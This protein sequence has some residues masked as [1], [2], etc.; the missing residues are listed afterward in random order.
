M[1]TQLTP[2]MKQYLDIKK[3]HPD[4]IL[5]FRLGDFYEMFLEDAIAASKILDIALTSRQNDVPMCGVPYH[6]AESYIARLLKAGRRIAICEQME[7]VPSSGTVVRREVVRVITP[8]TVV[9]ANL[10]GGDDHNFLGSIVIA[11]ESIGMAFI[12]VS[13]GDFLV[14]SIPRSLDAFRGQIARF[15][16]KEIVLRESADPEDDAFADH[17]R[18]LGIATC[19]INDW[20]YDAG[21]LDGVIREVLGLANIKGLGIDTPV[22]I[23]AAGSI[24]HYLKD[25]HRRA[26][27][28]LKLPQR[29]T[30]A[31]RMVLDDA[32]IA[33]LELVRN[34]N[35]GTRQRTLL[36]VLDHTRTAMGRRALERRVLEP[37]VNRVEIEK[38]L[39]VAQFFFEFHD[40]AS[41]LRDALGGIAD[42]ERL[43]SRFTVGKVFPRD[44]LALKN[45]LLAAADV[46][47]LLAGQPHELV[48]ALASLIPDT[49][50]IAG[51]IAATVSDD[52]ALTPEQGRVIREGFS[53]ELDRLY[54]LK[55]DSRAW[56]LKY[57]D[58]EKKKLGIP[59]LRVRYNRVVGHY[60][61][62]S[63]GQTSKVPETYYR[64]QTLVGS[65]RYTT[66]ELQKYEE[67]ILSATER[68]VALENA[69]ME[70]LKAF[71]LER[72]TII[73]Q[74][75]GAVAEA[76]FH[77]SLARAAM[78]NRFVRPSFNDEGRTRIVAG[79]HPTVEKYYT[80][81]VFIPNDVELDADGNVIM[82]LTGPNMS[83]KSTYI[84]MTALIQLMA[85]VGSFVPADEADLSICDRI[86]TRIG[87]SD[88]IA[89]GESTFLVEMN[90]AA[91]ILNNA[92]DHSLIIMDQIGRGTST[93]DGLSIAW[94]VV[95][96]ILRY[97]RAR[98][99][100]ATHYHE[101][102]SLGERR[103]VVNCNVLVREHL[104]GVEFLHR[105]APGA[106]DKSYGIHVARL[107]GIPREITSRAAKILE[108]L[109]R[110][111]AAARLRERE[112]GG[113][114]GQLEIFNAANHRVIQAIRNV[115]LDAITPLEALNEL[116][117]LKKAIE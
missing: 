32:T 61:E 108:G 13:T 110:R 15:S 74:T 12:D 52:P 31:E 5:F 89:R 33:S 80:A 86:F 93:Y 40:L 85:Q 11:D 39:D 16:P 42:I 87:A 91:V 53:D 1:N 37:L 23:M 103:G 59:T 81:E 114:A 25:A 113:P 69:G 56:L 18:R 44:F 7:A 20:Y 116:S 112:D 104:H 62:V 43:V 99:L 57:E 47:A 88:N 50:E 115:D 3:K 97:I 54:A 27:A 117:R 83:G 29:L 34:Q 75:A 109:E 102:T 55:R 63:K 51:R 41:R 70:N 10:L 6:A 64:K 68:T 30:A 101:L 107:A 60:I 90:E 79:R 94:A 46:K 66:D 100:F 21:Y 35:D 36:S 82:I 92:T 26:L 4:E 76:D 72:R 111:P 9:E 77:C 105:V 19:R 24:L 71:I 45:S 73:Q 17:L 65:E 95:E 58:G 22:E 49:S 106:A 98:T 38:R 28:H 96:Y 48:S 2:M 8:G 14:V 78:E 67:D 84:R